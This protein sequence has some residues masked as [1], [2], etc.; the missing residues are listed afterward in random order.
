MVLTWFFFLQCVLIA[1]TQP[2]PAQQE[3]QARPVRLRLGHALDTS[4]PVHKSLVYFQEQAEKY[5]GGTL[6]IR[7]FPSSKLGGER[8]MVEQ[9]QL[10]QLDMTKVATSLVENFQPELGVFTL[11]YLFRDRDHQWKV[12][13]S[14]IGRQ[15]LDAGD[16]DKVR[17][18]GLCYLDAGFRSFYLRSKPVRTPQDLHGLKIRVQKSQ[19][20]VDFIRVLGG[21]ATPIA[22]G[23]LY[24][25][26]QQGVVD[27]AENNIPSLYSARHFEV[28]PYYSMTEHVGIPDILLIGRSSWLKLAPSQQDALIKAASDTVAFHRSLWDE[29]EKANLAQMQADLKALGKS[30]EVNTVDKAAFIAAVQPMYEALAKDPAGATLAALADRIRNVQ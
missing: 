28:C 14:E 9:L 3:A 15:L 17:L 11:P 4:H 12:L 7:I 24:T 30:F 1:L 23:E 16:N 25:S 10:G 21:T 22:W 26:L 20:M 13:N 18:K 19:T 8:E 2:A 5:A 29:E 6:S 27:G